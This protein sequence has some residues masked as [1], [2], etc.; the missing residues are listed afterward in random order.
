MV[1]KKI[2]FIKIYK[3]NEN[4]VEA[5]NLNDFKKITSFAKKYSWHEDFNFIERRRVNLEKCFYMERDQAVLGY[6]WVSFGPKVVN[7]NN[8]SISLSG[9]D[10]YLF[11]AM[12]HPAYRGK[13]ILSDILESILL[14]NFNK[15]QAYYALIDFDNLSSLISFKKYG[16]DLCKKVLFF[17]L[18]NTKSLIYLKNLCE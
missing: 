10:A 12:V 5:K 8:L 15:Y 3:S 1:G 9:S 13:M 14:E 11:D 18:S 4:V 2:K 6:I 7:F 16:F 17:N